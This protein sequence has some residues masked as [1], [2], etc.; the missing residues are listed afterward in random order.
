[1]EIA[2]W[3]GRVDVR[4]RL[5]G[6]GRLGRVHCTPENSMKAAGPDDLGYGRLGPGS[7][8]L[9]IGWMKSFGKSAAI[10]RRKSDG[11][12]CG[13]SRSDIGRSDSAKILTVRDAPP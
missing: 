12:Q 5:A 13:E 3:D 2:N 11:A 7:R 4:G 10:C 8:L 6:V 1:M 9:L